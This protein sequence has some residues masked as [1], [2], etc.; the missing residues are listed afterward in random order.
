MIFDIDTPLRIALRNALTG[1]SFNGNS[2]PV[3]SDGLPPGDDSKL[4]VLIQAQTT[5]DA[6]TMVS[7]DWDQAVQIS[8]VKRAKLATDWSGLDSLSSQIIAILTGVRS[9]NPLSIPGAQVGGIILENIQKLGGLT[10]G[11]D[12]INQKI[13]IFSI[14]IYF[15]NQKL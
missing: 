9:S 2:V 14:K 7:T 6:S 10:D 3:Y 1:L 5:T 8:I 4:Y 11:V 13:L 15:N 12:V